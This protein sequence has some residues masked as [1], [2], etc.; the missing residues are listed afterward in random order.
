MWVS[1]IQWVEGTKRENRFPREKGS[2]SASRLWHRN[3]VWVSSL[4]SCPK[5]QT[6]HCHMSH[7]LL[8]ECPACWPEIASLH[9]LVSQFL[10]ISH[11]ISVYPMDS[12][13][14]ENPDCY[15]GLHWHRLNEASGSQ[16]YQ[17]HI[18]EGRQTKL[19]ETV[20]CSLVLK[21]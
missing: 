6:Q 7:V 8:P 18:K 20:T 15:T 9:D 17:N 11:S 12:I 14:L 1:L 4:T 2:N 13:S 10:K 21:T 19:G 3:P 16:I 5:F